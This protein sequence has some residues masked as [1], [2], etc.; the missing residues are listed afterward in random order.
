MTRRAW[1]LMGALAALWGASYLFIKLA[2]DDGLRAPMIVFARV[3][4]GAAVLLPLAVRARAFAGLR[5]RWGW[6]LAVAVCQIAVPFLL[7]TWAER[8]IPSALAGILVASTPIFVALLTP[9]MDRADALTRLGGVGVAIGIVGVVL[10]FGVDLS[11]E[12]K[13]A[14]GGAMVLLA[15]LGYAV[16]SIWVR[17]RLGGAAPVGIAAGTLALGAL[18]S[19]PAAVAAPGDLAI[20]PGTAAALLALGAGGTGIAFLIYYRLIADVGTSRAAVVAYLAPG[21]AVL[22]GAVF[23]AEPITVA[24]I[25]GLA[26]ILTGSWVA[27]EGR[28]PWQPRVTAAPGPRAEV[29]QEPL[30]EDAA[31]VSR[32]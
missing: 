13:L 29:A 19:L 6:V 1:I 14:L 22:Y 9:F 24:T 21:F 5:G 12:A 7:I 26:L 28:L 11:G 4:L 15:G 8:W 32:S 17:T 10:L 16:S 27:A 25:G 3:A 2:L 31:A 20:G 30:A 23:L 18:L